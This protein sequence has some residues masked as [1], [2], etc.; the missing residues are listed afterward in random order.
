MLA[1]LVARIRALLR[2]VTLEGA[3]TLTPGRD[4][5]P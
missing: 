2:A 4:G 1:Y 3:F 5:R